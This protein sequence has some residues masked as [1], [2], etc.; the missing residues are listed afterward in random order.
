MLKN[1]LDK[2]DYFCFVAETETHKK[3]G[4]VYVAFNQNKKIFVAS[5]KKDFKDFAFSDFSPRDAVWRLLEDT[6]KEQ[7]KNVQI[8]KMSKNNLRSFSRQEI[9]EKMN[10]I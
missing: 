6:N 1:D 8:K 9:I 5:Q 10:S 2:P 3:T 7:Y 4:F